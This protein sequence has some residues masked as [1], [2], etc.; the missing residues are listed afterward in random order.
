MGAAGAVPVGIIWV[1]PWSRTRTTCAM[2]GRRFRRR[3]R[4]N[5]LIRSC[6][7][8]SNT[9]NA[10][11]AAKL[12]PISLLSC[13]DAGVDEF[14]VDEHPV[15]IE[16]EKTRRSP[17]EPVMQGSPRDQATRIW[18][19]SPPAHLTHPIDRSSAVMTV[20]AHITSSVSRPAADKPASGALLDYRPAFRNGAA[21]AWIAGYTVH[22]WEMAVIRS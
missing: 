5:L 20:R 13:R 1:R 3:C 7:S 4:C 8:T 6:P 21:M 22:T 19:T 18:D 15:A 14:A 9:A 2:R 10:P 12:M 17:L 16:D 11:V